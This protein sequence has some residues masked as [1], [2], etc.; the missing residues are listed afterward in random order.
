MVLSNSQHGNDHDHTNNNNNNIITSNGGILVIGA[1]GRIG[2]LLI[3]HLARQRYSSTNTTMQEAS[4]LQYQQR[5]L[6]GVVY[7]F[8]RDVSKVTKETAVCCHDMFQGNARSSSDLERA[9]CQSRANVVVVC[10]GTGDSCAKSTLRSESAYAL[11]DILET[12]PSLQHVRVIVVS[13]RADIHHKNDN[14]NFNHR[15]A[16]FGRRSPEHRLRHVLADHAAQ[17]MAFRQSNFNN[18]WD[19]TLIV[20]PSL[21]WLTENHIPQQQNVSYYY[22]PTVSGGKNFASLES[23]TRPI[24][25]SRID[26]CKWLAEIVRQVHAVKTV[27]CKRTGAIVGLS[28]M[29]PQCHG[30]TVALSSLSSSSLSIPAIC[31]PPL[32]PSCHSWDAR[33]QPQQQ[34]PLQQEYP[35]N[36]HPNCH[37]IQR[38][39]HDHL[40]LVLQH[41][42]R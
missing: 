19:R 36:L 1:S 18:I 12:N 24:S 17:E 34:Q 30:R 25:S 21:M 16:F 8:C 29:A 23:T 7:G 10:I 39:Q 31:V 27:Y 41:A 5:P 4:S 6:V 37:S 42:I 11:V 13:S 28:T 26:F 20:R 2:S 14:N 3:Q 33:S 38:P 40:R 9:L 32:F 35:Q 22:C 15:H